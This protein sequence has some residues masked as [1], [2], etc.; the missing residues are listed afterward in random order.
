MRNSLTHV[1][2]LHIWS[3]CATVGLVA[4]SAGVRSQGS[5]LTLSPVV[6]PVARGA[7]VAEL[8]PGR[9]TG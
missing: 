5:A 6:P 3:V 2:R 8:S 1:R 7:T 4:P 9:C